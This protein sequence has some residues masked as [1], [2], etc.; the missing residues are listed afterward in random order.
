MLQDRNTFET[1]PLDDQT[2][3]MDA[4]ARKAVM[5]GMAGDLRYI[6]S[7]AKCERFARW[8]VRDDVVAMTSG[9][10]LKWVDAVKDMWA[11]CGSDDVPD[12]EP[13][14]CNCPRCVAARAEARKA[15]H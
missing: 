10:S 14:P 13:G 4:M 15:A 8:A 7:M 5:K 1:L 12:Y 2:N 6:K 11:A 9:A 3:L